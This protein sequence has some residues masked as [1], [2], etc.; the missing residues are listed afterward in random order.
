MSYYNLYWSCHVCNRLKTDRWPTRELLEQ[1]IG[2]VDLCASAFQEHFV[3]QK[4]GKWRGKT[5]SAKYT[6][7]SLRLNRPHLVELRVLLRELALE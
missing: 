5:L 3:V 2:Y 6:I 4:N 7:D 1:G